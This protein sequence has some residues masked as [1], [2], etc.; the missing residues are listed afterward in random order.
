IDA[1]EK[2]FGNLQGDARVRAE[3]E[4]ARSLSDSKNLASPEAVAALFDKTTT[5]VRQMNEPIIEFVGQLAAQTAEIVPPTRA[6]NAQMSR[7][8]PLLMQ[9]MIE[10]TGNKPY[11]D[12]N[13][14]LRFTYGEVKGY[15]PRDAASYQPFTTLS[16]VIEKDTGREPFDVPAKLKE[17]YRA[18]DF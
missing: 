8:R 9:G 12:A 15:V 1:V 5:Q 11:P 13:R 17:L 18:H 2:L 3:E 10:M 6:F 16:G 4:F 14:T 7:L